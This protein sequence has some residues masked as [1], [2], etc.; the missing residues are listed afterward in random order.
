ML[1]QR[2]RE[3]LGDRHGG[4]AQRQ[5]RAG[6]GF[7]FD[8]LRRQRRVVARSD[9][10]QQFRPRRAR[11]RELVFR[12]GAG[13]GYRAV[14]ADEI[15]VV[16]EV[17][18]DL[19]DLAARSGVEH[20]H[21]GVLGGCD[22]QYQRVAVVVEAVGAIDGG[23]DGE[24]LLAAGVRGRRRR[25]GRRRDL[26]H[27]NLLDMQVLEDRVVRL[28]PRAAGRGAQRGGGGGGAAPQPRLQQLVHG[29][30]LLSIGGWDRSGFAVPAPVSARP[31]PCEAS[32]CSSRRDLSARARRR[33]APS[34]ARRRYRG[35]RCPPCRSG[36]RPPT[37]TR[38]APG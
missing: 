19:V 18:E 29:C 7:L 11:D 28:R 27:R 35:W 1:A 25:G 38:S 32:S 37:G 36:R 16:V 17:R 2:H 14:L 26:R 33:C 23:V 31:P 8:E 20:P 9:H 12:F 34:A 21:I 10:R 13:D 24:R 6:G 3:V 15:V 30:V 4:A 5:E 22:R